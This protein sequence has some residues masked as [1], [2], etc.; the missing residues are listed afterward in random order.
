MFLLHIVIKWLHKSAEEALGPRATE[1][2]R[3]SHTQT[4]P[5]KLQCSER[6]HQVRRDQETSISD[7]GHR[8]KCYK[9]EAESVTVG[10]AG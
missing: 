10:L 8:L 4:P 1:L 5:L 2:L 3:L 7:R 6:L 9:G